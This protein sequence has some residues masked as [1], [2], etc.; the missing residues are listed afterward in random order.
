MNAQI[1]SLRDTLVSLLDS[2]QRADVEAYERMVD[3]D[4]TCFEPETRGQQ[5]RGIGFHLFMTTTHKSSGRYHVE[6]VDPVFR[7]YGDTGYA[8]YTLVASHENKDA[9]RISAMNE[10]RIFVREGTQWKMVHFHRSP[11][12]RED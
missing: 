6:I 11:A 7:V 12:S 5:I 8:S 9:P 1:Q 10:T 2:I 3:K 4:L